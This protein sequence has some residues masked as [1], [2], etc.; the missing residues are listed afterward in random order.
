MAELRRTLGLFSTT[1]L[2]V[3]VTLGAGIYAL[4]GEATALAGEAV[5]LSF[6]GG[7]V[8]AAFSALSYAELSSAIPRAGGEYHYVLRAFGRTP[9]FLSSWLL[10]VGLAVASAAVALGFGGYRSHMTGLPPGVGA[11]VVIVGSAGVLVLGVRVS[12]WIAGVCTVLEVG[13][14]FV[15]VAVG[16]PHVGEVDLL[17]MPH[18]FG[19][20]SAAAALI[21]FAFIGFEEIVQLAEEATDPARTVPRAVVLSISI[22]TLLYVLVAVAAVSV[23]GAEALAASRA[24]LADVAQAAQG[25]HV[26][27]GIAV[28]ALFST[29]NTVLVVLL[30]ASRLLYGMGEDGALPAVFGRVSERLGTPVFATLVTSGAAAGI[31]LAVGDIGTVASLTNFSLFLTFLLVNASTIALRF[32]EPDLPRPFRLPFSVAR[33]PVISLL[34]IVSVLALMARTDWTAVALGVGVLAVGVGVRRVVSPRADA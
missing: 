10:L 1:L 25:W 23:I 14:L 34:G 7:A 12:A 2:G 11:V 8:V 28:V 15:V 17:A 19:G 27:S 4:V 26:G 31:A 9:A 13:G 29:A 30:S 18:G 32:R 16:L 21:F 24:P 3:G 6:V 20:V 22:A 33:V 5:W